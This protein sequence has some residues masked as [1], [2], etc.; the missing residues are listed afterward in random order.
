MIPVY[1]EADALNTNFEELRKILAADN[2]YPE[3][4]FVDDG[5][6][7]LTWNVIEDLAA[8]DT[9][10]HGIRFARNFGK[11][12]ALG[13]G[14]DAL[15]ADLYL[16]MDSDLQHPP[17]YVKDMLAIIE[18][19]G[20]DIVE[21]I[22]SARG[23]ESLKY[24]FIAKN[25]Y[26]VLKSFTGLDMDNSSDFK[27]MKRSVVES[28]RD[29]N[30]RNLFFR[31]IVEWVGFEK[32]QFPFEV[33]DRQNGTSRFSAFKLMRL[34]MNAI[35]CIYQQ[36]TVPDCCYRLDLSWVCSP[37]GGTDTV[38]VSVG[39]GCRWIFNRNPADTDYRFNDPDLSGCHWY[40][41]LQNI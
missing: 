26:K 39:P 40:L 37:I 21:G 1:N 13:A 38:Y 11:E 10:V 16:M 24:K 23:S 29:F 9:H 25:F 15:E 31:G 22:K 4:M 14:L 34:A 41:Y 19:T 7:D 27:L 17:K 36:A 2:I 28:I 6:K 18:N 20:A 3:F 33:D 8:S 12:M 30:E 35:F 5:S 32:V